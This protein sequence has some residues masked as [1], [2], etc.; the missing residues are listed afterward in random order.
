MTERVDIAQFRLL[1][2]EVVRQAQRHVDARLLMKLHDDTRELCVELEALRQHRPR[3]AR[4]IERIRVLE[5]QL[6]DMEPAQRVEAI[7]AR[8][9]I[10]RTRYYELR[11]LAFSPVK[12]GLAGA[13]M[14]SSAV[15]QR[16]N[17]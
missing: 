14:D 3:T 17:S 9:G 16:N 6:G 10:G 7:C 8:L 1:L 11:Q 4:H 12:G 15:A 13:P 5:K 2:A